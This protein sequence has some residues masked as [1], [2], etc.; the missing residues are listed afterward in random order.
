MSKE[1]EIAR[2]HQLE[3]YAMEKK[4]ISSPTEEARLL[5]KEGGFKGYDDGVD[6]LKS[7]YEPPVARSRSGAALPEEPKLPPAFTEELDKAADVLNKYEGEI[8]MH[9]VM[10]E[11]D[12]SAFPM[13]INDTEGDLDKQL[14]YYEQPSSRNIG[15]WRTQNNDEYYVAFS[16]AYK[17]DQKIQAITQ[18]WTGASATGYAPQSREAIRAVEDLMAKNPNAKIHLSGYSRGGGIVNDVMLHVGNNPNIVEGVAIAPNTSQLS[19]NAT[20]VIANAKGVAKSM[21]EKLTVL[22]MEG[23]VISDSGL[24]YGKQINLKSKTLSGADTHDIQMW[25]VGD[26]AYA[27][28]Y[29]GEARPIE[30][31][32]TRGITSN[33]NFTRQDD[34]VEQE[35][36]TIVFGR[37]AYSQPNTDQINVM[38]VRNELQNAP[39]GTTISGTRGGLH[40]SCTKTNPVVCGFGRNIVQAKTEDSKKT[41]QVKEHLDKGCDCAPRAGG[42]RLTSDA[43]CDCSKTDVDEPAPIAKRTNA[44][45]M[46][47][48]IMEEDTLPFGNYTREEMWDT[49]DTYGDDADA[50]VQRAVLGYILYPASQENAYLNQQVVFG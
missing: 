50:R 24:P 11:E 14:F 17:T 43:S 3:R 27:G 34:N 29:S 36:G 37:N 49:M 42:R 22:R 20:R 7:T 47:G 19:R 44:M 18:G 39:S 48:D 38:D 23:D 9:Q 31:T 1:Y 4:Y 12:R 45:S 46:H 40:Y 6:V 10:A 41:A 35:D 25:Q 16:G 21:D 5:A 28:A 2:A 15:V 30:N 8:R 33:K 32:F 26:A 13:L